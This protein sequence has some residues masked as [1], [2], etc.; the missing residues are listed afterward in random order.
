[1][2]N[3]SNTHVGLSGDIKTLKNELAYA[4]SSFYQYITEQGISENEADRIIT[5][6]IE[7]AN[8]IKKGE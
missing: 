5:D 2:I 4:I 3:V 6:V 1:M 8:N 7:K